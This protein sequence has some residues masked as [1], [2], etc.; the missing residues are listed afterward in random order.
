MNVAKQRRKIIQAITDAP[1]T[2]HVTYLEYLLALFDAAV[3]AGQPQ[4]ASQ[5]LPMYEE[6]FH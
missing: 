3:V 1:D 5:F 6:E 2:E 4:P